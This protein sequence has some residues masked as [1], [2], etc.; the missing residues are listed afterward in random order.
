M[1]QG[2]RFTAVQIL[3]NGA[4]NWLSDRSR[5]F[6]R[7]I[8]FRMERLVLVWLLVFGLAVALRVGAPPAPSRK[9]IDLVQIVLFYG[10]IA[11]APIGGYRMA[12][13]AFP[14]DLLPDRPCVSLV[15][16]G[17]W[18]RLDP[19]SARAHPAF[20]PF[21]FMASLLVSLLLNIPI[22]SFEFL[23]AV[24]PL[25]HDAPLWA[26][27][28]FQL[29]AF[30]AIAMNFL[31]A[32]CFVMAIRSLPLFPRML[33]LAWTWDLLLQVAIAYQV[34]ANPTLPAPVARSLAEL[35]CGNVKQVFLS[36]GIWIPYLLLSERVNVTYRSR[37]AA[38]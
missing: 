18:R 8:Q 30:D 2:T 22:R 37:I 34:A 28:L 24:P 38:N 17:R 11:L 7:A 9:A 27:T 19:L 10:L 1:L 16:F 6:V 5:I 13:A 33:L 14:T 31:Y 21:G 20:G 12:M 23:L 35:L 3:L 26:V 25:N 15:P 29:M 32:G 36:M 4:R